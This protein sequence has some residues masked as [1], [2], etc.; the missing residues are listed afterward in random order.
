[1]LP[2]VYTFGQKSIQLALLISYLRWTEFLVLSG[3]GLAIV[4]HKNTVN[5]ST[6]YYSGSNVII[7][8]MTS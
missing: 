1:M 6:Y 7:L 2:T 3:T 5:R 4:V 8:T